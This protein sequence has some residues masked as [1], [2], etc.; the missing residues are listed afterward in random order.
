MHR[1]T[2]AASLGISY[3]MPDLQKQSYI[4][5]S[6]NNEIAQNKS[7][8]ESVEKEQL[9]FYE[10]IK[11][12]KTQ[13]EK[14]KYN[15]V[16][17]EL[18]NYKKLIKGLISRDEQYEQKNLSALKT[19][20][21]NEQAFEDFEQKNLQTKVARIAYTTL[22]EALALPG[23]VINMSGRIAA[24]T[25]ETGEEERR[26]LSQ[27]D[28]KKV[29]V[30]NKYANPKTKD[31]EGNIVPLKDAEGFHIPKD[32]DNF[33]D[34]SFNGEAMT[35]QSIKALRDM[36]ILGGIGSLTEKA[37]G[38]QAIKT[39]AA[40]QSEKFFVAEALGAGEAI[41]SKE[42]FRQAG[43]M[44]I[45]GLLTGTAEV[46][47]ISVRGASMIMPSV[48]LFGEDIYNGYIEQGFDP[49]QANKLTAL[50]G[51]IDGVTE[52]IFGNEIALYKS[53]IGEGLEEGAEKF[54][55]ELLEKALKEKFMKST[56]K[57]LSPKGM[58]FLMKL[59]VGS[60]K[61]IN[62]GIVKSSM[63]GVKTTFEEVGEEEIGL[64]LNTFL[65]NPLAKEY[66]PDY[67]PSE[68]LDAQNVLSTAI[69]TAA[70]MLIPGARSA[71]SHHKSLPVQA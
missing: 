15:S 9:N 4:Y 49:L 3:D 24:L 31:H 26:M 8:L 51:S 27:L 48:L 2:L 69:N 46:A 17:T 25:S 5:T 71:Y 16:I 57:E 56:G 66:K 67:S 22:K 53:L 33:K 12:A 39:F 20:F 13:E 1:G 36:V 21:A 29:G 7:I 62:S 28:N 42:G 32:I 54:S 50:Q 61:V 10:K 19:E 59:A 60:K 23:N 37:L 44:G 38:R 18:N 14:D 65:T 58:S 52:A 34:W 70:T 6:I 41:L 68:E 64:I 30:I 43:N 45:A 47:Q 63:E 40:T 35:Y 55:K 11:N